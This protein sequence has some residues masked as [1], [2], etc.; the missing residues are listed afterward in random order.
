MAV[1]PRTF[2]QPFAAAV[3]NGVHNFATD[4]LKIALTNIEPVN[5][6]ASLSSISQIA[7]GGGYS[8]G[9]FAITTTR[10]TQSAGVYKL[11]LADH[12]LTASGTIAAWQYAVLY[13]GTA[14]GDPL[15][16]WY[17]FAVVF[18]M[19]A[20]NT[21][22]FDFDGTDG[23]LNFSLAEAGGDFAD[24]NRIWLFPVDPLAIFPL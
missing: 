17:P 23:A 3:F 21:F 13:N 1:T 11:I 19:V 16:C 8:T 18:N 6:Y 10:S 4:T 7:A 22:L 24:G 20:T 14:A 5:T 9:G 15:I 2:F 12:T